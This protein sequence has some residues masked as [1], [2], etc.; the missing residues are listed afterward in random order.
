MKKFLSLVALLWWGGLF[1]P[2]SAQA[3]DEDQL[4]AWYMFFYNAR[5]GDGPFGVQGDAQFRYWNFGSDLEQILI[6]NGLTYSPTDAGITFTLGYASITSGVPGESS[7]RSHENRIYQ[8]A[9]FP[10][11]IGKRFLFTHRVRYE[12]RFVEGQDFRTRYRYNMFLNVPLNNTELAKKTV[13]LALYNEIFLNGQRNIGD[14]RR[15]ETFDRNRTYLG[16]GYVLSPSVRLQTGWMAQT[17]SA[18]SKN[19]FQLSLHYSDRW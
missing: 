13:Y 18:W 11:R 6:R 1:S 7:D 10:Q 8:E 3:V 4:G 5:F 16:V 17:T 2:L 19:Q 15:V 14:G 12:Q 9:L